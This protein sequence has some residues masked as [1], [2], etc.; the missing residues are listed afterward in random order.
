MFSGGSRVSHHLGLGIGLGPGFR[1][2]RIVHFSSLAFKPP[3]SAAAASLYLQSQTSSLSELHPSGLP[4]GDGIPA[5]SMCFSQRED[6]C[7]I[8]SQGISS[9]AGGV[10]ALG[11][12]DALHIG[13]RELAIQA[14]KAGV[15]FLLS[16]V[17]MAE[18]LGWEPRIPVVAKYDRPRVLSTWAQYCANAT[19]VEYEIEFSSVRS[20]SPR[21]FVEKLAKELG[22]KGVVAG[23]N[24]RFGYKASGDSSELARLCGEHGM[25]AYII[26]SV[27]DKNQD[28]RHLDSNDLKERGQVSST[29]VRHALALGEMEYVSQLL[30][31]PHRLILKSSEHSRFILSSRDRISAPKTCSLNLGP[32]DGTY[33]DCFL[34]TGHGNSVPCRVVIDTTHT[35][36]E[37][38]EAGLCN[39]N[40]SSNMEFLHIEFGS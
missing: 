30:G 38:E 15:P 10:V 27:M 28:L 34:V 39:F 40:G 26:S 23:E 21:Q 13:H 19:P 7:D 22:V 36:V 4:R 25:D 18:V 31:R 8:S 1:G 35:H 5:L 20:L 17:G 32:R 6:T 3:P 29:R 33:D 14:S 9:V 37:M 16:F 11:K 24:Y 2:S 12:F